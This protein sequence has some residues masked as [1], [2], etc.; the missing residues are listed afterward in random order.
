MNDCGRSKIV[1]GLAFVG[2]GVVV[3]SVV[4]AEI[5]LDK[6]VG[7]P[8]CIVSELRSWNQVGVSRG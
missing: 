1:V 6:T 8:I 5:C 4:E 3:D 2:T 7:E